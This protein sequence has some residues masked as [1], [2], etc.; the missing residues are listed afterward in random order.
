MNRLTFVAAT[1][2]ASFSGGLPVTEVQW[3]YSLSLPESETW[4]DPEGALPD[5]LSLQLVW[6]S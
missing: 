1:C 6:I 4:S 3:A 2:V 5:F